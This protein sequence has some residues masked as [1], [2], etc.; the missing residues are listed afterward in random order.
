MFLGIT[1]YFVKK[2]TGYFLRGLVVII[3]AAVTV[4]VVY[5]VIVKIDRLLRIPIPGTQTF[6]PGIGLIVTVLFITLV[7]FLASNILAKTLLGLVDRTFARVPLIKLIYNAA[8]DLIGA[9]AGDKKIFGRPVLVTLSSEPETKVVG[10]VTN[11]DMAFWG[12]KDYVTVYF[13]QSYNF[14]GNMVI[15]PRSRV[16]EIKRD[17]SEVMAFIVSAGLSGKTNQP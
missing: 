12:M 13:P 1:G 2:L 14:A 9:F 10:F 17:S 8:K 16:T 15:V 6:F 11:E 7:G 5:I 4:F 3:P